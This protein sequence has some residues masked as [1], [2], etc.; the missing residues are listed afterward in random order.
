M[1]VVPRIFHWV[2]HILGEVLMF[3]D[4]CRD[5]VPQGALKGPVMLDHNI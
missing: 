1:T 2:L 5:K 3:F 4:G